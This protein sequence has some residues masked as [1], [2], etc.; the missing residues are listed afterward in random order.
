MQ[1]CYYITATGTKSHFFFSFWIFSFI[2]RQF[3][4]HWALYISWGIY[5]NRWKRVNRV[6]LGYWQSQICICINFDQHADVFTHDWQQQVLPVEIKK[7]CRTRKIVLWLGFSFF[8]R[9]A[10]QC[11]YWVGLSDH[12]N[13]D[14]K[15]G[16]IPL[17]HYQFVL[18]KA[19]VA[20]NLNK[21]CRIYTIE[22][23][24]QR[25]LATGLVSCPNWYQCK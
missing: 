25:W 15:E 21:Q 20:A 9:K 6:I 10:Q 24:M 8:L 14:W 1:S 12:L 18:V 17:S 4:W 3:C 13:M 23:K 22:K 5:L 19:R 2:S 7:F 11:S 16:S